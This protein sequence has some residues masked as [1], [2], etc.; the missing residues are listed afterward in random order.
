LARTIITSALPYAYSLP[1]LGNFVGSV[2][3]ADIYFKYLRMKGEDVIFICGSDQHGTPIELEAVRR[4][5]APEVLADEMHNTIKELFEKY[6]CT[7]TKYGKTHTEENKETVYAVFNELYRN[8]YILETEDMQ[9]YCNVDQR[10]LPDR[11]IQGTCPYCK[12]QNARGDQC[13]NCDRLLEPTQVIDPFCAVCGKKDIKFVKSK[14]L[15]IELNKLQDKIREFIEKNKENNWSLDA[16]NKSLSSVKEGL[17][18]RDITRNMKWGF[19]VPLAGFERAVFYVWC[20]AVLR[21][22]GI[23]K[24]WDARKWRDYWQNEHT[25]LVQFLGKDNTIFHTIMWP[26]MLI[27]SDLGFVMP[28]TIKES[29]HLT[30]KAFKFSKSKGVGLN[31]QTALEIMPP[32]FWRFVLAYLYPETADSELSE[33]SLKESVNTIMNDKIGNFAQRVL[34]LAKSNSELIAKDIKFSDEEK[35]VKV[36]KKYDDAFAKLQIRK[37]MSAVVEL[38]EIGNEIMSKKEPWLLVKKA[39]DD[40]ASAKQFTRIFSDLI[41]ITYAIAIALYPI[42]PRASVELLSYF[43]VKAEPTMKLL[44]EP[45]NIDFSMEPK[46]LFHKIGKDELERLR[47][48]S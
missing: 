37:V 28:Y 43:G 6:D 8:G 11:F 47:K 24:E 35:A 5:I 20:D 27:G 18:P 40:K 29:Q 38:A 16:V 13:N 46:P 2:L 9:A 12:T 25:Q 41:S 45:I 30:S 21:Y 26:A 19:Q 23:T 14:N 31:M 48:F 7:F 3:P 22:I 15:A 4:K 10:F 32:D 42:T 44:E 39:K 36:M 33:E 1:H 17:K 34:K